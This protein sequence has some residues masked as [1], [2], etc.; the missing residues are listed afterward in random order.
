MVER[1][2]NGIHFACGRWPLEAEK[3]TLLFIHGSGGSHRLWRAQVAGL[4]GRANTVA[5]DLPG[6]GKSGGPGLNAVDDYARAV[7]GFI[8][9]L[10]LPQPIP[11]GLSLGGAIAQQLLLD[12]PKRFR[13]G[14]L[15][16]TGA[17]LKVLPA[18]L[19]S[20]RRDYEAFLLSVDRF[21]FS[22]QT[23][24]EVKEAYRAEARQCPAETVFGDFSACDRFDSMARLGA[25]A[26]PVLVVS[27]AD[28][29]LTPPKYA[30]WLEKSIP[31]AR[32]AHLA[33]AGHM[34][35][36]ERPEDFNRA[37]HGFLDACAL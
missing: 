5:L 27:A 32:R 14:V 6:H 4:A 9:A 26:V 36:L 1:T 34:V 16:S 7:V 10:S 37:L 28:D 22:S 19:E 13:A 18:I 15:V 23:A 2:V 20:I 33:G 31:G 3:S 8:D 11:C 24:A 29:L 25:I 21:A 12:H 17:R 35:P 30:D